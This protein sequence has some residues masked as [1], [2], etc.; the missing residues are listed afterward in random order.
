MKRDREEKSI[1][2]VDTM[3]QTGEG[4]V[5]EKQVREVLT[6]SRVA[7]ATGAPNWGLATRLAFRLVFAL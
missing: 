3:Q 4:Q 6:G 1:V 2:E 7:I 5:Q